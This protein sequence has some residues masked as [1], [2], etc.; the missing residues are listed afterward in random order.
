[1][2]I[3]WIK[4]DTKNVSTYFWTSTT[5]MMWCYRCCATLTGN[6]GQVTCWFSTAQRHHTIGACTIQCWMW[7]VQGLYKNEYTHVFSIHHNITFK[8]KHHLWWYIWRRWSVSRTYA[9]ENGYLMEIYN[10]HHTLTHLIW[11][12]IRNQY[13]KARV[14]QLRGKVPLIPL[15]SSHSH[16]MDCKHWILSVY[17]FSFFLPCMFF[18]VIITWER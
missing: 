13:A 18:S 10:V 2:Y 16:L 4:S 9:R 12:A 5:S 11:M 6:G 1:M 3:I 8:K 14:R 7:C 17:S 15:S